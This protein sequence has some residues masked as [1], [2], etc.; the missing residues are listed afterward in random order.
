M[1][2]KGEDEQVY[3]AAR[4]PLFYVLIMIIITGIILVFAFYLHGYNTKITQIP[5]LLEAELIANRFY[6]NPD[7]FAYLDEDSNLIKSNSIDLSKFNEEQLL[8]CYQ[9]E[10]LDNR[11]RKQYNFG[12]TLKSK[13]LFL[14]TN[15]YYKKIDFS[16]DQPILV[17]KEDHFE[18]DTLKIEVQKEV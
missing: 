12:I 2:K 18:L 8:S 17:W 4:K 1:N 10:T 6:N 7:C 13:N 15:N 16:W 3:E 11:G 9:T 14:R 5:P